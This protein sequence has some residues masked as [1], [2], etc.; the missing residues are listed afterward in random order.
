ML[1][2]MIFLKIENAIKLDF[3]L[4]QESVSIFPLMPKRYNLSMSF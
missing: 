4:L 2:E 1:W 3:E